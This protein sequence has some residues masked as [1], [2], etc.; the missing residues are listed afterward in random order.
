MIISEHALGRMS[1]KG[2]SEEE[3][4]KCVYE[5]VLK[6]RNV[7]NGEMRQVTE[8]QMKDKTLVTIHTF[9]G[10]ERRVITVYLL[11]RKRWQR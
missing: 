6:T 8:L 2:I 7:V 10:L 4:K 9:D 3:V 11:A 5:G 1:S